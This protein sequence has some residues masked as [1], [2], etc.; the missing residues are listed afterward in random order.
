MTTVAARAQSPA[1]GHASPTISL[2]PVGGRGRV[3]LFLET[4]RRAMTTPTD[5]LGVQAAADLLSLAR[6]TVYGMVYK[7]KLRSTYVKSAIG[8]DNIRIPRAD[9]EAYAAHKAQRGATRAVAKKASRPR[10]TREDRPKASPARARREMPIELQPDPGL[11]APKLA[12]KT[13]GAPP[14]YKISRTARR[15]FERH[16]PVERRD[17]AG[18][19]KPSIQLTWRCQGIGCGQW[20]MHGAYK[21]G[22]CNFCGHP[23]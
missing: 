10:T 19:R 9:V 8:P 2:A 21:V 18:Y 15:G 7:A 20:T 6:S 14:I 4:D 1:F 5:S 23:R 13:P 11:A 22:L 17:P 16:E 3:S 12:T